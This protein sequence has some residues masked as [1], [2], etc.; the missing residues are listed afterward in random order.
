MLEAGEMFPEFQLT[1]QN[2]KVWTLNDLKGSRTVVYFY[3]KDDTPG[4]TVEACDFRDRMDHLGDAKVLGV[5]MD[6]EASHKKFADKYGLK[7]PLLADTKKELIDAVGA[8]GNK[9]L[10]GKSV[11]GMIRCT[12]ILD[13]EG[14]IEKVWKKVKAAGHADQVLKALK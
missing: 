6:N 2:G 5:S 7:F 10:Y 14:R 9:I 4:C 13:S 8:F 3:P 12:F 11:F 1:D